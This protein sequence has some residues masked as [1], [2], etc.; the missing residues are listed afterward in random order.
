MSEVR[1]MTLDPGHFHAAL[2][3]KEMYPGVASNPTGLLHLE[4]G[5]LIRDNG[6]AGA[7]YPRSTV[8]L[9]RAVLSSMTDQ[10]RRPIWKS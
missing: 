3:Q 6:S 5:Q 7:D 1:L 8:D 2:V 4:K 10:R 9:S